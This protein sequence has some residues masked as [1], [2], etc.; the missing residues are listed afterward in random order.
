MKAYSLYTQ[1]ERNKEYTSLWAKYE[2]LKEKNLS[3]N[4]A[5]GKPGKEQLNL[6]SDILNVLSENDLFDDGGADVRNYGELTGIPSAKKLFAE[7]LGVQP[8]EIFVGGNKYIYI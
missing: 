7:I 5:R 2:A 8:E 1:T 4:M 3:L 6:V